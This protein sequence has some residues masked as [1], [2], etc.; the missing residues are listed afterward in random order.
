MPAAGAGVIVSAGGGAVVGVGDGAWALGISAACAN[1]TSASAATP[2]MML[3]R[4]NMRLL[5]VVRWAAANGDERN[6]MRP[7]G[8]NEG[9]NTPFRR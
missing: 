1:P 8:V 6:E 3:E 7:L 4:S 2:A 5:L 9:T